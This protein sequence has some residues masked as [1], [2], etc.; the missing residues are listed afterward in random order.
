MVVGD[1]IGGGGLVGLATADTL[2]AQLTHQ[3]LD[4]VAGHRDPFTAQL[5]P[6]LAGAIDPEVLGM[7]LGDLGPELAVADGASRGG[8]AVDVVVGGRGDRQDATDRLDPE[9]VLVAVDEGNHLLGRRSSSAML[10][11]QAARALAAE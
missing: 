1:H 7:H 8:S 3:P 9:P 2:Q 4:G 11:C 5:P 6:D 10:L